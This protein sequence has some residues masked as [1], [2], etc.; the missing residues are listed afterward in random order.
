MP[1][2]I[3]K[4]WGPWKGRIPFNFNWSAIDHDSTVL[5]SA[6]EYNNQKVRFLGAASITVESIVPHSPPYDPNGNHGVTFVLNIDLATP[7]NVVTDI[8]V[9]DAKPASVQTYTPPTPTNIGLRVQ[10][11]QSNEWCWIAIATSI[12]KY[13]NPSSSWTQCAVM[14]DVGHRLNAFPS[15]TTACPSQATIATNPTL[16]A[17]LSDPYAPAAEY[18]LDDARWGVD[19]RYLKSGSVKDPLITVGNWAADL[20]PVVSLAQIATE[21]NAGRP[22]AVDIDW[23]PGNVGQHVVAI[24]G[25][26]GDSLL[27]LD[28]VNGTS[29]MRFAHFPAAYYGG[30]KVI[31][32]SFTKRG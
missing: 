7:I 18:I 24:A 28:P 4:Y 22:V 10:Y 25:V 32:Y 29:V 21:V 1:R 30:A 16:A 14:T 26:L 3:R 17:A 23:N 6:S 5:I 2:T 8:T 9:L 27:L 19:R 31:G 11:Q 13:Y 12:N 20:G 15:N